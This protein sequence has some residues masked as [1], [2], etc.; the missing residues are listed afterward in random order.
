M[1]DCAG[2]PVCAA[3][4]RLRPATSAEALAMQFAQ[5]VKYE[6]GHPEDQ[7]AFF[8]ARAL[9]NRDENEF[10]DDSPEHRLVQDTNAVHC[11]TAGVFRVK[12]QSTIVPIIVWLG[13]DPSGQFKITAHHCV[14]GSSRIP[15]S[16]V[17]LEPLRDYPF[18]LLCC[19]VQQR[20]FSLGRQG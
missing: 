1:A 8:D 19:L 3:V 20:H 9:L 7:Q 18:R 2:T 4:D 12:R 6:P 15:S 16:Q 13:F 10:M 11:H 17:P 14:A 5:N